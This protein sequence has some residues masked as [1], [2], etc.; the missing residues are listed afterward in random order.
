MAIPSI[1]VLMHTLSVV[2]CGSQANWQQIISCSDANFRNYS[3]DFMEKIVKA[4]NLK[5]PVLTI[6]SLLGLAPT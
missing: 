5:Q 6:T 2:L 4:T 1:S 3:C